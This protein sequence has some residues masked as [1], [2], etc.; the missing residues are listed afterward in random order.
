MNYSRLLSRISNNA[1]VRFDGIHGIDHWRRVSQIGGAL[2]KLTGAD[3][4]VVTAFSW[5]HDARRF[6]D[7]LDL[8]HGVRGAAFA[9][10][11]NNDCLFL[12]HMQLELLC[13][14]CNAHTKGETSNDP[15]IGTCWDAD[16]LDLARLGLK[17]DPDLLSTR[18]AKDKEFIK[19]ACSLSDDGL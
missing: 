13:A 7:G 12:D 1:K 5:V 14:A 15:T 6:S 2:A 8:E 17:P 16:R 4:A 19:W 11:V 10:K 9:R 3:L 18:Q